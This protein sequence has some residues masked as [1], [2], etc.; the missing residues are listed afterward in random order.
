MVC[1]V[2][3][4]QVQPGDGITLCHKDTST[5]EQAL[6]EVD[7]V[8]AELETTIARLDASGAAIRSMGTGSK[9]PANDTAL[10]CK[11]TLEARLKGWASHLVELTGEDG[12][13]EAASHLLRLM[14]T[15][16]TQDWAGDM[17]EEILDA[18]NRCT[19][20]TDR[21]ADRI[22]LGACGN[23]FE[24]VECPGEMVAIVGS[25]FGRCRTCGN[26]CDV[27]ERQRWIIGEAWHVAAPLTDILRWLASSG[28]ANI[29]IK[30]ARAWV[31]AGKLDSV[32]DGLFTPAAVWNA[33]RATPSG[34]MAA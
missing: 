23:S 29:K 12:A 15:A 1:T 9:S 32:G 20:V 24:G 14:N 25:S 31:Y 5:L 21:A 28:H 34:R 3:E 30:R 16:R 10:D 19:T 18:V 26:T 17:F 27:M 6:A 33:Y 7:S 13:S 2:T 4:C 11:F 22:T 8:L